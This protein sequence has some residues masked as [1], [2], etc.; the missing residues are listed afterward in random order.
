MEFEELRDYL[1]RLVTGPTFV[2]PLELRQKVAAAI[3]N[4]PHYLANQKKFKEYGLNVSYKSLI[5]LHGD[6]DYEAE[7]VSLFYDQLH[8]A[9]MLY[10]HKPDENPWPA[11]YGGEWSRYRDYYEL[12]MKERKL[13]GRSF[14][15]SY[16]KR[17]FWVKKGLRDLRDGVVTDIEQV[18][19]RQEF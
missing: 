4:D 10:Y 7:F 8:L 11:R 19:H 5:V 9:M 1:T 15:S 2:A 6:V 3:S 16:R 14:S 13:Q 17:H 18:G 12:V